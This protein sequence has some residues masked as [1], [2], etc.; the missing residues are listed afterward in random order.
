MVLGSYGA[1]PPPPRPGL[2]K[3]TRVLLTGFVWSGTALTYHADAI[4]ALLKAAAPGLDRPR[5]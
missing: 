1:A 5:R 3:A 2:S 4:G